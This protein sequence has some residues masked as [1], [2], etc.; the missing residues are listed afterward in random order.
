MPIEKN[1]IIITATGKAVDDTVNVYITGYSFLATG[2]T[3]VILVNDAAGNAVLSFDNNSKAP[4]FKV[5]ESLGLNIATL[6][7]ITRLILYT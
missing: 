4:N 1:R 3:W 7:N 5:I 2:A 6:T